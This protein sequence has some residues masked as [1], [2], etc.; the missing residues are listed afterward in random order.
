[1]Q[2]Y[3]IVYFGAAIV[4]T[5]LAPI[6]SRMGKRLCL[7]EVHGALADRRALIPRI[8]GIVIV[9]ATTLS[10][11]ATL[12]MHGAFALSLD[13]LQGDLIVLLV[14]GVAVF[15]AGLVD[16]LFTLSG[17]L[18]VTCLVV[19]A[20]V[21]CVSGTTLKAVSVGDG[22]TIHTGLAAWPLTVAWIVAITVCVGFVDGLDG[23]AGGI[24]AI[25]SGAIALMALLDGQTAMAVLMLSL[26]GSL[27]GFLFFNWHPA[28]IFMGRSGSMFVGFIVG[29]GSLMCQ[30]KSITM[31]G[32]V[33]PIFALGVPILDALAS[34][35][36]CR[37]LERRSI[38][39]ER[40]T[41][42]YSRFLSLGLSPRLVVTILYSLTLVSACVGVL[43][44][45]VRS[46]RAIALAIVGFLGLYSLLLYL[47]EERR[48]DVL[49]TLK[50]NR[51][52]GRAVRVLQCSFENVVV[53]APD[54]KSF[55][56]W[57]RTLCTLGK[58]MQFQSIALW[59]THDGREIP[60]RVWSA[61]ERDDRGG[62][63]VRLSFPVGGDGAGNWE[64]TASVR[65]DTCLELT[66]WRAMLLAR[67]LDEF[68]IP[69]AGAVAPTDL[70]RPDSRG[71]GPLDSEHLVELDGWG[72]GETR[73]E[74]SGWMPAPQS[75]PHLDIV[76]VPVTPFKSYDQ[77]LNC[78]ENAIA[79][80]CKW[81]CA[82]VNPIKIHDAWHDPELKR[83]L[84]QVDIL[85]C[86][87]MGVAKASEILYGRRIQRITGCDL[88]FAL[89]SIASR[90]QWGVYLLGASRESNS[91]AC[92]ALKQRY[93]A[94]KIAGARD[95]YFEDSAE[96]VEDINASGAKL[97]FVAMGSPKQEHWISRHRDA[98]HAN[99]CMGV[100]GSFDVAAGRVKRAPRI[101][102][103]TG[104][105]FFFRFA[106]EPR[107]RLSHQKVLLDF[108][109]RVL[110]TRLSG[111]RH[112]MVGERQ[113][114]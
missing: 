45:T 51:A 95:G 84:R 93:P 24:T 1:M 43:L 19:A 35:L 41:H 77:A 106:M 91:A 27:T 75:P 49:K 31:V 74:S 18:K 39:S 63:G 87:G 2:L 13:R 53:N 14:V 21:I 8:G 82:A 56:A 44:L 52:I 109:K 3:V 113:H 96:V 112:P 97:L 9:A 57:W 36:R 68:P 101:F 107:K 71:P 34:V 86:D 20:L 104:T 72:G 66:G 65:T 114:V 94:L 81:F 69:E 10:V 17:R 28:K 102:R 90:R 48:A 100:G 88:F 92:Q 29:A 33:L 6:V 61:P 47:L 76:G 89:L 83:L 7:L 15:L 99:L 64:I 40:A 80:G 12:F 32:L 37:M 73:T 55:N 67:L 16:D 103:M 46:G 25:V 59:N 58:D 62:R 38:S 60:A 98:I 108:T 78:L 50:N 79:A 22:F 85:I 70:D 110:W 42:L 30:T 23:L 54:A 11:L 111:P 26:L 5:S 4:A 105:E